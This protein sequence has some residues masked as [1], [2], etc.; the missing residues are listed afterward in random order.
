MSFT[1][2]RNSMEGSVKIKLYDSLRREWEKPDKYNTYF[3]NGELKGIQSYLEVH[4]EINI[5]TD[6]AEEEQIDKTGH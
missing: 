6:I 1:I 4:Y 5:T 2:R 3:D